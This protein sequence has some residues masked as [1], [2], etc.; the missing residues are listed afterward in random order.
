MDTHPWLFFTSLRG[1]TMIDQRKYCDRPQL[2]DETAWV[3][4]TSEHYA[5][6][7]DRSPQ[8]SPTSSTWHFATTQ[9][10][11]VGLQA[12]TFR[13]LYS[14]ILFAMENSNPRKK[15][16]RP[17][18]RVEDRVIVVQFDWLDHW[19]QVRHRRVFKYQPQRWADPGQRTKTI[20]N[21]AKAR[22]VP[23]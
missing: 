3:S 5:F 8:F 1:K 6:S 14:W 23:D 20:Q 4:T 17:T 15:H 18:R 7:G 22:Q 9:E 12:K 13:C 11:E 21:H 10:E 2:L 19:D 16:W